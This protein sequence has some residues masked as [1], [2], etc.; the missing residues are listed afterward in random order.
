MLDESGFHDCKIVASNALDRNYYQRFADRRRTGGY[1]RC[2]RTPDYFRSEPVFGG[3]Y[4]LVA[5][6]R[7]AGLFLKKLSDNV[8]K[9]TNPG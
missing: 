5:V 3:V 2:R 7:M 9:I 6:K 1:I 4:K 8:G